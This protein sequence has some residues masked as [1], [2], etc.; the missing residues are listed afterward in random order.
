VGQFSTPIDKLRGKPA[1]TGLIGA[2]I[3][4]SVSHG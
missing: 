3:A 2:F 1:E 4:L